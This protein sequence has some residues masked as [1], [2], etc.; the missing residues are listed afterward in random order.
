M[1]WDNLFD[2]LEGQLEQELSAEEIDL[3]AEEERLRLARM[4]LRDRIVAIREHGQ[5]G[6]GA[7]IRLLLGAG[8]VVSVAPMTFGRDWFSADLVD[9]SPRRVQCIVPLAAI[10]GLLLTRDQ[11]APS[12]G[13]A[14]VAESG[15][16]L[17]GRL[18][19]GFVLRDLCRRRREIDLDIAAGTQHGTIDRVGRDHLDLAVHDS[20]TPRRESAVRQLRVVPFAQV[21]LVRL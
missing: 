14:S 8:R 7:P 1:R 12:L 3:R 16:G 17:S 13:V 20:G 2:D 21:E 18:G 15:R 10:A 11:V 4:S 5:A 9:E 19:F 6:P